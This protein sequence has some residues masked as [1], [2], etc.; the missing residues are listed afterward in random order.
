MQEFIESLVQ[1]TGISPDQAKKVIEFL[2]AN[3]DKLPE[4]LGSD[5]GKKIA[6]KLPGG[7]GKLFG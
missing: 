4:W 1:K 2:K 7:I 5:I 6:G 3:A